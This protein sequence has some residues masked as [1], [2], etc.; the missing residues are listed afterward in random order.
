ALSR[1]PNCQACC[2]AQTGEASRGALCLGC[3]TGEPA[4]GLGGEAIVNL[5][6]CSK[7][8]GAS[9]DRGW[10]GNRCPRMPC[11]HRGQ[12]TCPARP[13][14]QAS[15]GSGRWR[16]LGGG[17]GPPGG[18]LPRVGVSR[19]GA[20][21]VPDGGA[22]TGCDAAGYGSITRGGNTSPKV[23]GSTSHYSRSGRWKWCNP[24]AVPR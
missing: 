17:G 20:A 18:G 19:Q 8:A 16:V 15:P 13:G 6:G 22:V 3:A 7:Q 5:R 4:A 23:R 24:R 21:A 10:L 9:P 12:P 1:W 14:G 2:L 11:P